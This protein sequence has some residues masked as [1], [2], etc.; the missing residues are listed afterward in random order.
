[1][2]QG[3]RTARGPAK[4]SCDLQLNICA[5]AVLWVLWQSLISSTDAAKHFVQ[6]CGRWDGP[7]IDLWSCCISVGPRVPMHFSQLRHTYTPPPY[8]HLYTPAPS[9][10]A[11]PVFLP[12]LVNYILICSHA[13]Q[14]Q[15]ESNLEGSWEFQGLA[16]SAPLVS[17]SLGVQDLSPE[18]LPD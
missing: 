18:S 4:V 12:G 10:K 17:A 8:I 3:R 9:S 6:V 11:K 2:P 14:S 1:M 16:L 15:K 13:S 5:L 7:Y